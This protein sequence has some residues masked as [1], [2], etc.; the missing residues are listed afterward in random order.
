M[1]RLAFVRI[2]NANKTISMLQVANYSNS[3]VDSGNQTKKPILVNQSNGQSGIKNQCSY[4]N[5]MMS[6]QI[7]HWKIGFIEITILVIIMF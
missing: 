6:L 2:S 4:R 7:W 1:T 3:G 5:P